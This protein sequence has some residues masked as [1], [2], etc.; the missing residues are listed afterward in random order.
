MKISSKFDS[1]NIEVVDITD[2]N[3]IQLKIRKDSNAEFLQWFHFRLQGEKNKEYKLKIIN[4]GESSYADGWK[5]YKACASYDRQEW[6]RVP[7]EYDGKTLTITHTPEF[8]SVYYSYFAPYSH[9]R[10]LD[11]LGYA[12]QSKLTKVIDLGNTVDGRDINLVNIGL[13]D[14]IKKKIWI[15]AR[16]H[17]GESMAE[18]FVDG[19][20]KRLLDN[21]DPISKALL[22][23]A[24]FYIV[25]NMN[26]DG[27]IN[28]NLRSNAA[29]ANLNRE[30]MTPSIEKSPEVYYVREKM[31]EIGIDMFLDI[32]G[33]EA[34]PYN[35]VATTEGIPS[36]NDELKNLEDSFVEHLIQVNPDFQNV[37]GYEKDRF[38]SANMTLASNYIAEKFGCLALTIEMPFKD[39]NNDPDEKYG[40]SSDRSMKLGESALNSIYYMLDQ[41]R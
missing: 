25:P 19:L 2:S 4:A 14:E 36:Y 22:K 33:D 38:G 9:E 8:E 12:Q 24:S 17:P 39:N 3:N 18:W 10:H 27:S 26:L 5:D 11:L 28:G 29:G 15:I 34:I 6:F 13:D 1:G 21:H 37:H 16:Q 35:F 40:W 32:H 41:L 20:I 7:T 23:K 31:H 30:W